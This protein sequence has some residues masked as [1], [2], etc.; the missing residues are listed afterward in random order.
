MGAYGALQVA[1]ESVLFK[2]DG[3]QYGVIAEPTNLIPVHAHNFSFPDFNGHAVQSRTAALAL[4]PRP[5]AGASPN[6]G[7]GE[8]E[9]IRAPLSQYV[10]RAGGE[11]RFRAL[12]LCTTFNVHQN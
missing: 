3:P 4:T 6:I 9:R 5:L 10:R 7:M 8:D 11:G 1:V 2:Q 12:L